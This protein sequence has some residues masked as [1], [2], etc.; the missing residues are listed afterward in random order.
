MEFEERRFI[1]SEELVIKQCS[2]TLAGLKT[3]SLFSCA[4][5]SKKE[6]IDC[7]RELN[8]K[9]CVKGLRI[10][11]L[12][13]NNGRALIYVYRPS[14][15]KN[16]FSNKQARELLYSFGYNIEN[17]DMC[18]VQLMKRLKEADE[19]PHEIGLF[20]GYPAEDVTG[21]IENRAGGAKFTGYWKVYGDLEQA[22]KTFA[23]YKKCTDVYC[24]QYAKGS[25]ISKLTVAV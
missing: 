25:N 6:M 13:Y 19:F 23:K 3:G 14:K 21:F 24:A 2:P 4:V 15:L 12:R 20:L 17:P 10:L 16:D 18:V 5:K 11:P 22:K 9:L 1:M 7:A 8:K